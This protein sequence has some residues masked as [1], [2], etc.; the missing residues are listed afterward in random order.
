MSQDGATAGIRGR[1]NGEKLSENKVRD[2]RRGDVLEDEGEFDLLVLR[3]CHR[4]MTGEK[5]SA[6][7][8]NMKVAN[9]PQS[10]LQRWDLV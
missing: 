3:Q 4:T 2:G 8:W 1:K 5:R 6:L 9:F 7:C 10:N